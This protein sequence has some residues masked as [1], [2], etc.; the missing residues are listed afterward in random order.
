MKI[1]IRGKTVG[2][3]DNNVFTKNVKESKHLMRAYDAWGI[4]YGVFINHLKP[5]NAQI[6]IHDTES[7]TTYAS[8]ANVFE[9]HGLIKDFGYGK[10]VFL[11]RKEFDTHSEQQDKLI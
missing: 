11:S 8:S 1:Q 4:D 7:D 2:T 6:L 3:L 5:T 10:Q 9:A